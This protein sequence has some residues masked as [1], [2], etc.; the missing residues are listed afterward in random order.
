MVQHR[1]D[2]RVFRAIVGFQGSVL[3]PHYSLRGILTRE[4]QFRNFVDVYLVHVLIV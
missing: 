2:L 1:E 4:V 3:E